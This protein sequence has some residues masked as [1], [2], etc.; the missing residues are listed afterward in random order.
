MHSVTWYPYPY[1][2]I[3]NVNYTI[4]MYIWNQTGNNKSIIS[5]NT[6]A[7]P[8]PHI[9]QLATTDQSDSD[10]MLLLAAWDIYEPMADP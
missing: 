4:E 2:D 9:P 1:Y 6:P 5:S 8:Q 3:E 10:I 7:W